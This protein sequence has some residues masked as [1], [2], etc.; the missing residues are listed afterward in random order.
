[1]SRR[2]LARRRNG[3]TRRNALALLLP[4][5]AAITIL[6]LAA[7]AFMAGRGL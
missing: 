6:A 2:Q 7:V 5:M 4:T 1:L 3:R